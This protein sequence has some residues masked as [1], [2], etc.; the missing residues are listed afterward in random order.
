[1][2]HIVTACS[3]PENLPVITKTIPKEC[4]WIVCLDALVKDNVES[5]RATVIKSPFTGNTGNMIKNY[6]LDQAKFDDNDWVYFLDDDNVVHPEWFKEVVG[7]LNKGDMLVW[8]QR[9]K[10]NRIRLRPVKVPRIKEIDTASY[11]IKWKAL[12][13]FRFHES[14]YEA[15]G[16]MAEQ[17]YAKHGC[18]TIPKYLCYYN[19]LR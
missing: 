2:I 10:N 19:F 3:R 7:N 8:G 11:M 6:A 14:M 9:L 17:V 13:N 5:N 16:L 18:Y 15:D 12:K 4:S 1:M